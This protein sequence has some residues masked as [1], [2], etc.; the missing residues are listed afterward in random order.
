MLFKSIIL[1]TVAFLVVTTVVLFARPAYRGIRSG[2]ADE[3][4][5]KSADCRSCHEDHYAS[6]ARTYHSRMTQ[7]AGP[8][9]VQGDFTSDNTFEYLG[10]KAH[11][12]KHDKKFMMTFVFPRRS[13][14][15]CEV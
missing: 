10:V 12:E 6:W 13:Q 15:S 9:K 3:N 14:A 11:M 4:Y 8:K 5:L 2:Y 7:D 1:T